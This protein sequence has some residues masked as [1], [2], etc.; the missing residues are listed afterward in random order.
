MS[1]ELA[2]LLNNRVNISDNY[3]QLVEVCGIQAQQ[4]EY[5]AT[6]STFANTMQFN[7][8]VPI[9]A[10]TSTLL[11]KNMKIKYNVTVQVTN[12]AAA[13]VNLVLPST[14]LQSL[15][16][17][18]SLTAAGTAVVGVNA[19]FRAFPLQSVCENISISLNNNQTSWNARQTISGL[20]RLL[21][22]EA[23]M[24]RAA[25][26]PCRPE[27]SYVPLADA[28]TYDQ[29]LNVAA[30]SHAGYSRNSISASTAAIPAGTV[31][32]AGGTYTYDITED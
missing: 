24:T 28:Y 6:N 31:A 2:L 15:A 12:A 27:D 25:E 10:L 32:G 20:Q 9:G 19:G 18:A 21:K 23:L 8:I 4:Y 22:K 11:S 30:K 3:T 17:R 13:Y 16:Q 1:K 14:D 7:N 26:C 29:N 5:P